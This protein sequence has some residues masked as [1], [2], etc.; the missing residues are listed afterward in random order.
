MP[1]IADTHQATQGTE[2]TEG[3]EGDSEV[4]IAVKTAGLLLRA[5]LAPCG[6]MVTSE[7]MR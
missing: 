5:P 1:Q 6:Q 4:R 3:T 7:E 2:G